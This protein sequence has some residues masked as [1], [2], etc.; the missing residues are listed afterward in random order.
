MKKILINYGYYKFYENQA[1]SKRNDMLKN[2]GN[3][4]EESPIF[5]LCKKENA[6]GET[7]DQ[8]V[9]KIE[10]NKK[11]QE[12]K[13]QCEEENPDDKSA[14]NECLLGGSIQ[15]LCEEKIKQ[16]TPV[17]DDGKKHQLTLM[18]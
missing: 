18:L 17:A 7:E 3:E 16:E 12:T 15:L 14:L 4:V 2:M 8:C 6:S 9:K 10:A 1:K 5:S 11:Y 13:K